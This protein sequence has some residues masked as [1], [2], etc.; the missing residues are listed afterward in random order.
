MKLL[1]WNVNHRTRRMA[2]SPLV[3]EAIASLTP[4]IVV[5][6]EYVQ[7]PSHESFIADLAFNGLNHSLISIKSPKENQVLVASRM[8]MVEGEIKAPAI[9]P[10]FPTNVLHVKFPDNGF[11]LLGLRIP[12]YSKYPKIKRACWDWIL[13]TASMINGRPFVIMGD[14]NTD[15]CYP[16][17]KCGDRIGQLENA[18]WQHPNPP[19]SSYWTLAGRIG[20]RI[21]HAFLT[22]D[23]KIKNAAYISES[24][25]YV[26]AGKIKEAMSDHAA[27]FIEVE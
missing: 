22:K 11:E 1:T 4:D 7:G 25:P 14:F 27:L 23:F 15:P 21:D 17:A 9:G 5:L 10:S 19:G 24:G 26:F 13:T 8:N 6:T 16:N 18:G 2:I 20:K 3:A 12:D